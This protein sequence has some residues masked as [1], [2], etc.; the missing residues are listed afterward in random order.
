M[1]YV[2]MYVCYM[3]VVCVAHSSVL[4]NRFVLL[5]L[6][7]AYKT[8][9]GIHIHQTPFPSQRVGS[10]HETILLHLHVGVYRNRILFLPLYHIILPAW[11]SFNL[12]P[13]THTYTYMKLQK[14]YLPKSL[15]IQ[16]KPPSACSGTPTN[17]KGLRATRA[18][19]LEN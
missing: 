16:G 5:I 19:S 14:G 2:P 18:P 15:Q 3:Y 10:W 1:V 6:N 7:Y 11:I 4:T 17:A 12:L 13:S 9:K 8:K